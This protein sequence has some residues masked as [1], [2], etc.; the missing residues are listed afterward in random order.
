MFKLVL[1]PEQYYDHLRSNDL[2]EYTSSIR[3]V[4]PSGESI[5]LGHSTR[6][7]RSPFRARCRR[8]T[9]LTALDT[10]SEAQRS[11]CSDP[12]AHHLQG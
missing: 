3:D 4:Q 2:V 7:L 9:E 11:H 8:S 12:L 10:Q 6:E 1:R 5:A